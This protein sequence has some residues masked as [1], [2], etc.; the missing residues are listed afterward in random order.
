MVVTFDFATIDTQINNIGYLIETMI[1]LL[2][3]NFNNFI[4]VLLF[5]F[6]I[7]FIWAMIKIFDINRYDVHGRGVHRK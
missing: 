2:V 7:G 3:I 5:C 1:N 4:I 6:T